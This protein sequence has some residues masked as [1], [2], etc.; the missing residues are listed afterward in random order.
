M[1]KRLKTLTIGAS[2]LMAALTVTVAPAL[3]GKGSGG[4]TMTTT[5]A[6]SGQ[7]NAASTAAGPS[8]TGPSA[9]DVTRS[10]ADNKYGFWVVNTCW[11]ASGTQRLRVGIAVQWGASDS[12]SGH[13]GVVP[14]ANPDPTGPPTTHCSAYV[15]INN[16]QS[17]D[18]VNY[19]V[20]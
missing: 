7:A 4:G 13:T 17:G 9:F 5:I 2:V 12:L 11:D 1:T 18:A 8:V 14:T 3:A 15:S 20:A 19:N 16:K 10:I 6:L